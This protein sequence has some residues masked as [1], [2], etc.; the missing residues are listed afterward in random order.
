MSV[1]IISG[2]HT[3]DP[4]QNVVRTPTVNSYTFQVMRVGVR[5]YRFVIICY[6]A[7]STPPCLHCKL[8]E[9]CNGNESIVDCRG[10]VEAVTECTL[11]P[12]IIVP[13]LHI[14]SY[15]IP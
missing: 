13:V 4:R 8:F 10:L 6:D 12:I 3:T 9:R 15:I 14:F 7:A 2:V 1:R 5:M 11:F